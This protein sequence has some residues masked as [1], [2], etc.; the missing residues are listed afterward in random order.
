MA[1]RVRRAVQLHH[2]VSLAAPCVPVPHSMPE[3]Y[4]VITLPSLN[5]DD[6][7]FQAVPDARRP[8]GVTCA[9]CDSPQVAKDEG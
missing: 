9:H 2:E 5:E 3:S 8:D 4:T 1:A 6:K 7:D